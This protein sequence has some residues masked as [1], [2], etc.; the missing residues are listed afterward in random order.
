M[1]D[2]LYVV[3]E[4]N[5]KISRFDVDNNELILARLSPGE[6]FGELAIIDGGQRSAAAI[7]LSHCHMFLIQ[8]DLFFDRL[9]LLPPLFVRLLNELSRKVRETTEKLFREELEGRVRAAEAETMRHR[10]ITHMVTGVAHELNTPLGN[11]T[12]AAS[13]F[14]DRFDELLKDMPS[15][16]PSEAFRRMQELQPALPLLLT[17]LQRAGKLVQTFSLVAASQQTEPLGCYNL[18]DLITDAVAQFRSRPPEHSH[19][20]TVRMRSGTIPS[21]APWKGYSNHFF[22]ILVNILT[23]VDDHAYEAEGPIEIEITGVRFREKPA[24]ALT[25]RDFGCGIAQEN[26]GKIFDAFY[27]TARGRGRTGLGLTVA[28]NTVT[29]PLKGKLEVFSK[30]GLGTAMTVVFPQQ[31]QT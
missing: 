20:I 18:R 19:K 6:Y 16:G 27:T 17:S 11:A 23:N 28:L 15:L 22:R 5:V 1:A 7:T 9:T 12:T 30:P 24:Y 2:C 3:L 29:G 8:R 4:G 21:G 14:S 25:V 13:Y 31:I 26:L 10:S